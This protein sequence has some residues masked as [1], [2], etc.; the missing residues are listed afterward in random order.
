MASSA[1][2]W[3]KEFVLQELGAKILAASSSS[4]I[5]KTTEP[6]RTTKE[7]ETKEDDAQWHASSSS[8]P[9]QQQPQQQQG[10]VVRILSRGQDT[11]SR[12]EYETPTTN[13]WTTVVLNM[14]N[15]TTTT[16]TTT[17]STTSTSG[18]PNLQQNTTAWLEVTDGVDCV[19]LYFT[20][21]ALRQIYDYYKEERRRN[22]KSH[23]KD[24]YFGRGCCIL[25]KEYTVE[26]TSNN[27]NTN[28][29]TTTTKDDAMTITFLVSALE[30]K[31]IFNNN[32]TTN[33][34]ND[35]ISS[36]LEDLEILYTLQSLTQIQHYR[37]QQL[38]AK[39]VQSGKNKE[40]TTTM[41]ENR[42]THRCPQQE[43]IHRVVWDWNMMF[44]TLS[45]GTFVPMT[46]TTGVPPSSTT[47][48]AV[49]ATDDDDVRN[50]SNN[51][52]TEQNN[53]NGRG[54]RHLQQL[55]EAIED[56]E[57]VPD[58]TMRD[59]NVQTDENDTATKAA[60]LARSIRRRAAWERAKHTYGIRRQTTATTTAA[61]DPTHITTNTDRTSTS[62]STARER[63]AQGVP[64]A[65][66]ADDSGRNDQEH[67]DAKDQDDED[68][69]EERNQYSKMCI[70]NVLAT[71]SEE[72]EDTDRN[73]T[74]TNNND[75]DTSSQDEE[76]VTKREQEEVKKKEIDENHTIN[77]E[78]ADDGI[79][80]SASSSSSAVSLRRTYEERYRHTPRPV[81]VRN[82]SKDE[83]SNRNTRGTNQHTIDHKD[84]R[85]MRTTTTTKTNVP[86]KRKH[87]PS[88]FHHHRSIQL[89][90]GSTSSSFHTTSIPRDE[91][92]IWE[93]VKEQIMEYDRATVAT[94]S[95]THDGDDDDDRQE[96]LYFVSSRELKR[97]KTTTTARQGDD[98][99]TD[100]SIA[101][102]G[103]DR[104][105]TIDFHGNG[106]SHDGDNAIQHRLRLTAA[107][108]AAVPRTGKS[109]SVANTL[110]PPKASASTNV[111]SQFRLADWI[112]NNIDD[113][114]TKR[115]N[116]DENDYVVNV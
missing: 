88:F 97:M 84:A 6:R 18:I 3:L 22:T 43:H 54:N 62:H 30:S 50:N 27:N 112:Q 17:R 12:S 114:D 2:P 13:W 86:P 9:L 49:I 94:G 61:P 26:M 110:P 111:S 89:P 80:G 108:A 79:R 103:A 14:T 19:K 4:G 56:Q 51:N 34:N 42:A 99:T 25:L 48:T 93:S 52:N 45:T 16:S 5:A 31:S 35:T 53:N 60:A 1:S 33:H 116:E 40:S 78:L 106:I 104:D 65:A 47:A 10:R 11:N 64:A 7:P 41:M 58:T 100:N 81:D 75:D 46:T 77:D 102:K 115:Q 91:N 55:I 72:E 15:T 70:Q 90:S 95:D 96:L 44:G 76:D 87:P 37:R 59:D 21:H 71:Q 23:T 68:D 85:R 83:E 57:F 8:V 39:V 98:T 20:R 73:T 105:D 107:A 69:D 29:N 32:N 101:A 24:C 74:N 28:T 38:P 109:S 67:A 113:R 82:S 92:S 63:Q 66:E 36:V